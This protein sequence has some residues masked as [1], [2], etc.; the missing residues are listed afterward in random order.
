MGIC[1]TDYGKNMTDFPFLFYI[2]NYGGG[3]CV[4]DCPRLEGE[5][6]D[7]LTDI[8][9]LVTY[10]GLFRV[11]GAELNDTFIQIGDYTNSSDALFCSTE[12]CF[13]NNSPQ[14]SWDSLGVNTGF[15]YAYYAADSY[16]VLQR[17]IITTTA[18]SRVRELVRA[19]ST[20]LDAGEAGYSFWNDLYADIYA[21]RLYILGFGFAFALFTSFLYVF[22]LRVPLLLSFTIWTSILLTIAFFVASGYYAYSQASTWSSA[23]PQVRSDTTINVVRV[24]SFVLF[25]IGA[26]L[27]LLA[28]CLRRQIQLA[29]GCVKEAGRAMHRMP[30]IVFVPVLQG[31][32]FIAF[33]VPLTFYG[34]HLASLGDIMTEDFPLGSGLEIAVRTWN[35]DPF[36]ERCAW[37][38]LFCLFWT[39][40]FIV[41]V[42]DMVIAMSVAKWYFARNK[43]RINSFTV[44]GSVKDTL[45]Y[46]LGTCAFGSLVLATVQLLRVI[47]SKIQ[48]EVKKANSRIAN[49]LLCCCQCCLWCFEKCIKFL[50]KNAYIQTAIFGTA[51]CKSAREAFL[52]IARNAGRIGAI[53]YVSGAILF[54]GK[55]FISA[56]TTSASFYVMNELIGDEVFSLAGPTIFVFIISY[57]IADMF[58]D[59]FDMGISTVL[60]CFIADEEMFA[61]RGECYAEGR[62]RK[63]IDDYEG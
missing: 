36:V 25:G 4:N 44:V 19:N 9:T 2:N 40:N 60:Q 54:I 62:L 17:C 1:G 52:L 39:G 42:G 10:G 55:L 21:A 15:G 29:V 33:L 14:E 56:A 38:L 32:G 27:A 5:T 46:H 28:C 53:T 7:N 30:G 24:S 59:I 41:A 58:L 48:R 6:A 12:N 26:F 31:A 49:A 3:V 61:D 16:S 35:F 23:D 18:S 11:P 43:K 51:F 50:N 47:L 34:V 22:I 8:R 63:Y 37:Y 45:Y 13:P 20:M 57:F